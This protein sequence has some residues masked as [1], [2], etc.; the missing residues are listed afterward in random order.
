LAIVLVVVAVAL[1]VAWR[2]GLFALHD[3]VVLAAAI[4][5]ARTVPFLAPLFVSV[6]ALGAAFGVPVTPLTIAGGALFGVWPG[7]ALNWSGEMLAATIAFAVARAAG[8]RRDEPTT[9]LNAEKRSTA[10]ATLFRLR[11]VPIAPFSLL[12]AGAAMSHMTWRDFLL[13]TG[14]GIFPI[15]VI[16]T[17]SASELM[18]GATGSSARAL[19]TAA[20][21][22]GVLILLTLLPAVVRRLRRARG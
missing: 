22:A 7:I 17:V 3:R 10:L 21:S 18:S 11:L 16:Y 6:F 14:A 1:I 13:A 5:R 12:N 8:L 4:E 2:S 20:I 9:E 15:T 19:K